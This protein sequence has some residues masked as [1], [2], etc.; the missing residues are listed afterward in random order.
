MKAAILFYHKFT[1]DLE[2]NGFTINPYNPCVA[3]KMVNKKQLTV[4][5][6]VD[7]LKASHVDSKAVDKFIFWVKKTY[8][9]PELGKIKATR[10][11]IHDYLGRGRSLLLM[12]ST[13]RLSQF[14]HYVC[15]TSA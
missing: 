8:G 10:G 13:C 15:L 11:K 6:H 2:G 5:Y 12:H 9:D 1:K 3:N 4:T 7:D 14:L